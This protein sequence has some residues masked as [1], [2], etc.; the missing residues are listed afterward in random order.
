MFC[1]PTYQLVEDWLHHRYPEND[2]IVKERPIL[3]PFIGIY[4]VNVFRMIWRTS[5]VIFTSVIAMI[6]PVFNSVLGLIGAASFWPLTVY[7]PVEMHISQA[8][9]RSFSL[10]WI[11]LKIL[12]GACLVITLVAAAAC[13]QGIIVEL[14]HYQP[15]KSVS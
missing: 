12:S 13:V 4:N 8:K 15:F 5:Y 6:F 1:Q 7:F 10:P 14:S 2:F 11:W 9:I 3:I